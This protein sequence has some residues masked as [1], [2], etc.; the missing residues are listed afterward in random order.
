MPKIIKDVE[1]TIRNCARE[2]FTE[3]SYTN[4]D[5]K[6]ISGKSGIAVGTMY[7]YYKNKKQL[8]LSILNENWQG[9]FDKLDAISMLDISSEEKLSLFI[10]TLYE[11]IEARNG[12]GKALINASDDELK[13]DEEINDLKRRLTV[14]IENFFS[15]FDKA[16][17]LNEIPDIDTRLA[18][19]LLAAL[20]TMLEFMPKDKKDNISFLI[21]FISLSIK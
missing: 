11:D 7:N 9:T 19:S 15:C 2:L 5:M 14:K 1:N 4:V 18:G 21:N 8:Y 20:L 17:A 10:S 16:G 13:D 6:M 12:L 3:L